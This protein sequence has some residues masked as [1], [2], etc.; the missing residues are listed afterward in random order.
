MATRAIWLECREPPIDD[1]G[2]ALVAIRA[3]QGVPVIERFVRQ[4]RV[5]IVSRRP[6]VRVVA[7]AAVHGRIKVPRVL[8]RRNRTVMARRT[9][10]KYLIVIDI[11]HRRPDVRGVA[12]FANIRGLNVQRTFARCFGSIVAT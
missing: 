11:C 10:S 7:R 2:I 3:R 5:A 4:A 6:C 12:V 9:G 8:A 1:I